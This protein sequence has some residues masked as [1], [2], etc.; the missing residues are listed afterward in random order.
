MRLMIF[1]FMSPAPVRSWREGMF[2]F[3]LP[4]QQK[5]LDQEVPGPGGTSTLPMPCS[6]QVLW[7]FFFHPDIR[8]LSKQNMA[9]WFWSRLNQTGVCLKFYTAKVTYDF[10]L[11]SLDHWGEKLCPPSLRSCRRRGNSTTCCRFGTSAFAKQSSKRLA[12]F[13]SAFVTNSAL[14]RIGI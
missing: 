7:V 9:L 1:C 2:C 4:R 6:V 3:W 11:K 8:H 13:K 10:N 14:I 12:L 5:I